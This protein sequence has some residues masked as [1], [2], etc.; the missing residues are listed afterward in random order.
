MNYGT[1][2]NEQNSAGMH[3]DIVDENDKVIS[4]FFWGR[5]TKTGQ[6]NPDNY[7][8]Y[9]NGKKLFQGDIRGNG[10]FISQMY[11]H[12]FN[13]PSPLVVSA[14]NTGITFSYYGE[15]LKLPVFEKDADWTKPAKLRISQ[16]I[17]VRSG[18][19][20]SMELNLSELL[21]TVDYN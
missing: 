17:N 1:L 11:F 7:W 21:Y 15:T 9:A 6:D 8:S 5:G 18:Q 19:P 20:I 16:F 10:A 12:E 3:F 2:G 4:R 13:T 14:D